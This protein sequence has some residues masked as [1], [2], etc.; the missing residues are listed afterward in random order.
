MNFTSPLNF[1]PIATSPP[2]TRAECTFQN[3][4]TKKRY[5]RFYTLISLLFIV[6]FKLVY[7]KYISSALFHAAKNRISSIIAI[8]INS[9]TLSKLLSLLFTYNDTYFFELSRVIKHSFL[10]TV[11]SN[12][13]PLSIKNIS[14][15]SD[16]VSNNSLTINSCTFIF[17]PRITPNLSIIFYYIYY[18]L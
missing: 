17:I 13:R 4:L 11:N 8:S 2:T 10:S 18:L 16:L 12:S 7:N 5:G 6:K 15:A 3:K 14:A 9:H 1:F